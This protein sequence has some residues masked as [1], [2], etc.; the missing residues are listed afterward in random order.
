MQGVSSVEDTLFNCPAKGE[1]IMKRKLLAIVFALAAALCI[2]F[3][4]PACSNGDATNPDDDSQLIIPEEMGTEGLRYTLSD[5]G[6]YYIVSGIGIDTQTDIV[7]PSFYNNLPVREIVHF[8][9]TPITSVT[10]GYGVTSIDDLAFNYCSL[11]ESVTIPD[12]VTYIGDWAF[13][14]C[15]LLTNVTIPDSITYIGD[16][17]FSRCDSLQYNEHENA[18]YLGNK[19]N[20]YV[21][22]VDVKDT[23]ST[24][25]IINQNTKIIYTSALADCNNLTAITIPESVT[26][27]GRSAFSGCSAF[28]NLIIPDSVTSIGGYAFE[29]CS[30]L[31]SITIP[32]SVTSIGS[33]AFEGCTSLTSFTIPDSVTSI[34]AGAFSGCTSLTSFTIP[35]SVTSI[36]G[37]AFSGCSALQY[38]E[39]GNTLYLGNEDN[40]YL[41]LIDVKDTS[42][43]DYTINS[44]TKIIC[45]YAFANCN[46]LTEITIPDSVTSIGVSVFE[47]CTSLTNIIIP[48]SITSIEQSAFKSCTSLTNIIIPDSVTSIGVGAF[49]YCNSLTNITIPD[50]VTSIGDYTFWGCDL[51]ANITIPNTV[52]SIGF[53]AFEGCTTLASVYFTGTAEDWN[54]IYISLYNSPLTDATIYYYSESQPTEEGDYWHY[55][56]GVPTV[57]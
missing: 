47:G 14:D 54:N 30:A 6:T 15:E 33:Y 25:Y 56:D 45:P 36:G 34:G 28:T 4:L 48:D 10:I 26:S 19:N 46:N 24:D 38:N 44:N 39:Y 21:V 9:F 20:P 40:P 8:T 13:S 52:T 53:G 50:S 55:V 7:I 23:P 12:S 57:W 43:P 5:D 29:G 3:A 22:L 11:L 2:A 49:R 37:G 16:D 32:D 42:L 31:T 18:L 41:A 51:L 17:A 1:K 27:I 35:D